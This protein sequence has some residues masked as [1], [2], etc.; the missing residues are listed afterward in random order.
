MLRRSILSAAERENLLALPDA[1]DELI[2]YYTFSEAD[3]SIIRQHRG[4]ANRL[5]FAVQLCYLRFPGIILGIDQSPFPPLLKQA[6]DQLKVQVESWDEYGLREQTRREH[7]IELQTW[8]GMTMFPASNYRP[9]VLRLADLARRTDR[10]IVLAEALVELPFTMVPSSRMPLG[11]GIE[12]CFFRIAVDSG[13]RGFQVFENRFLLIIRGTGAAGDGND[14]M[15]TA[16]RGTLRRLFMA[17]K[18]LILFRVS[19][20][21]TIQRLWHCFGIF[22]S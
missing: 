5:G 21:Q 4:A 10:G 6:A 19:F 22:S 14:N 1:Q 18:S 7:L 2:R 13:G 9:L 11:R 15:I 17:L 16:T 3:L 8:L 20:H 12:E